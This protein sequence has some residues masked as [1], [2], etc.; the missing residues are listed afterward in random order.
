[1]VKRKVKYYFTVKV[2]EDNLDL[3]YFEEREDR[4]QGIGDYMKDALADYGII[5]DVVYDEEI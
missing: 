2:Y 3:D 4:I 1:M 5:A